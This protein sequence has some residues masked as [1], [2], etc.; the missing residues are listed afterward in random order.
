MSKIA[1]C[2]PGQGSYRGRA[3]AATSPRPCRRRWTSSSAAARR[4]ASTSS[5]SASTPT[6][7]SSRHRGAAA[8]ARRDVARDARR[9][10]RARHRAGLRR[11]PLGRRVRRARRGRGDDRSRRR[12]RS[13]AS[14]ASR[15]PRPPRSNPGSMAAI[16]GLED[17]VVEALCRR[18]L[19]VWPANYNCPGPDRRLRREPRR[20]RVHRAGAGARAR[21]ARSSSR[22]RARST[23]RSSRAPPTG[24]GPRSSK[25][26][27]QEPVAPFMSTVTARVESAQRMG[28][29]LVDQLTAPVRFTQSATE[30]MREGVRTFVEV[31]P[32]QRALRASSSGSTA[33]S[34]P[35]RSTTSRR[36][37]SCPSCSPRV[38]SFA[39]LEGKRALVTGASRGI[40]RAI[41][42]ELARGRRR[43]S[44]S[45]TAPARTRR[46]RSRRRSAARAVQADVSSAEDAARLVEEAGD[47]DILVN[48]AGLTRDGL[49]AR[50]SDDDWRDGDR[51]EPLVGLLHVPRGH[52]GR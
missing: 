46:R 45:A 32:G 8:G 12:S 35:S 50:M 9:D 36:S 11:R 34:R 33:A 19:G 26:K 41:A 51:D 42:E 18:I 16:L 24:C 10:A 17:E 47:L 38:V 37:T 21:A 48:N 40:G 31:G 44:S 7:R 4:A 25:V 52:A 43:R 14:A 15:W 27:F 13:C 3:W 39:S 29:L 6:P 2:F 1:F 23:R 30:L 20:R 5:G 22:S 49:L 28:P